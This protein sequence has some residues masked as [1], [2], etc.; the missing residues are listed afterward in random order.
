MNRII[1]FI[2]VAIV[3][4]TPGFL[5]ARNPEDITDWYVK[6][7]QST[8]TV[9]SDSSLLIEEKITA[10]AGNLPDKHGIFR[11]VPTETKTDRGNIKTPVSLV[12]ITDFDGKN[13][14]FSASTDNFNHTITWKIGDAGVTVTGL[15]YYNI[16]YKVKNAVR[17]G[18]SDF[19][20]LYWNLMGN[21]WDMEIDNFSATIVFPAGISQSNTNIYLYSGTLGQKGNNLA[22]YHWDSEEALQVSSNRM[23]PT[24]QGITVSATFPKGIIKPYVP[25]FLDLYGNY[26]WFL[27]PF[28][29]F[30]I[31][32][33]VWRRYGKDPVV[34]KTT[35]PEFEIPENLTP[36]EMGFLANN[37]NFNNA[38]ISATIVDLAVKKYIVIE[39]IKKEGIFGNQ[40]FRLKKTEANAEGLSGPET[41]LI[42]KIFGT[43]REILLS[44]LKN[45]FNLSIIDIKQA[46]I[47]DLAQKDLILKSG[48]QLRIYFIIIAVLILVVDFFTIGFFSLAAAA[49]ALSAAII[50]VFGLF[51]P[52]RTP[53]G[54]ELNWRVKGFK[55]YMET[56]EKYRSRFNEKENIFEKFLPYA[57]M[58]GMAKLWAKKMEMIYGKEYFQNYHPVWFVGNFSAGFNADNFTSQINSISASISSNI[59]TTSGSSGSGFSGGG[60]GGGG[61]GGW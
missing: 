24:Q 46:A 42:N 18:N 7:F 49:F 30:L 53:K 17:S 14:P 4:A 19:D 2:I 21:F 37:G 13:L 32:L 56:A 23:I 44:G 31:C 36:M 35:I 38:L 16:T 48:L 33:I 43:D 61:G 15:N 5:L 25:G 60:G 6:D 26:L 55:L 12:S 20:E 54:A 11:I 41:V 59:G 3:L 57:I 51:M 50:F 9:Q 27:I 10:D 58:F 47:D 28:F 8:I 29:A 22:D 40:D 34:G 39:E 1:Y 52:K 45:K